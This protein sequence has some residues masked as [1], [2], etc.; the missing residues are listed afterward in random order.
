MDRS[1][2]YANNNKLN[3][4][5]DNLMITKYDWQIVAARLD[6]MNNPQHKGRLQGL[7]KK[8]D[9]MRT[10]NQ[11]RFIDLWSRNLIQ[12]ADNHGAQIHQLLINAYNEEQRVYHTLQHIE[13]CLKL[14]DEI[15]SQLQNPDAVELAIWFHDVIYQINSSDNEE[16]SADLFM[17]MSED[18]L[19]PAMRHQIYQH[20]IA[21]LHNGSEMLDHDTRYMVDID[22]SSFGL[23]WDQFIQNSREVREEM[24]HIPDEVFYPKQCAFQ[25]SLLKHGRFYQTDYFFKNYEQSALNNIADYF[26]QLREK[27]GFNCEID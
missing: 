5:S 10:S 21:T 8:Q 12:G 22:L 18:V 16:L 27:T 23:P 6:K 1:K 13:D 25:K 3:E 20:I 9:L 4:L 2:N 26:V 11:N 14:F 7:A 17:N 24:S 19:E 15:K